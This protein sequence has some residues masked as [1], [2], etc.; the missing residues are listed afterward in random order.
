MGPAIIPFTVLDSG[1]VRS[2][3]RKADHQAA[4]ATS[5]ADVFLPQGRSTSTSSLLCFPWSHPT[6][7]K[8][9]ASSMSQCQFKS[10]SPALDLMTTRRKKWQVFINT[11]NQ[12]F[13][14]VL[15][16]KYVRVS[17]FHKI[18]GNWKAQLWSA[19]LSADHRKLLMAIECEENS[20]GFRRNPP[21]LKKNWE[22]KKK[23]TWCR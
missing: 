19:V 22:K 3:R 17:T 7:T 9:R 15:E 1:M 12:P 10:K 2:Y 8:P 14:S 23:A 5:V 13:L 16:I 21:D 11:R 6:R 4:A 18:R 20:T